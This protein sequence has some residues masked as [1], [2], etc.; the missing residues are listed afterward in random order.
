MQTLNQYQNLKVLGDDQRVAILRRL[1]IAP[2]SLSDLGRIFHATPAHIRYHLK[3]LEQAGFVRLDSVKLVRNLQ[4]KYYRASAEAYQVSLVI[5]PESRPGQPQLII[6]SN[7]IALRGLQAEASRKEAGLDP[8]VLA[9]DSLEGLVKLQEG[10]CQMATCHLLDPESAEY[11]R[12][13][14]RRLF[15][16]QRMALM[17]LYHRQGGLVVR[18]GNP[19]Q[20]H[21]L[22]DLARADVRMVNREH[23]SGMRVW[24]DDSLRRMGIPPENLSG[25]PQEVA[26]HQEVARA[27]S[28]GRADAGIGLPSGVSG[29]GLDFIPLFE[30]PYDL[31]LS[32]ESLYDSRFSDFFNYITSREFS[33][34]VEKIGGYLVTPEFG[35]VETII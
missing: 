13:Y 5:L 15:A 4:E 22:K 14:V 21:G 9:M 16:G 7:D 26:S 12:G 11:N 1:M 28:E 19:K 27:V 30:E 10:I 6:G 20:I 8:V 33:Q 29:I 34:S 32:S 17:H 25:Y 23:G 24:L 2:A 31:V 18:A 35:S 3:M